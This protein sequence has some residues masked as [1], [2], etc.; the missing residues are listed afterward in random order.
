MEDYVEDYKYNNC[1]WKN[2]KL[3]Y[4]HAERKF[5]EYMS[6]GDMFGRMA[7]AI[8]TL[9]SSLGTIENLLVDTDETYSTR[10]KGIQ[11]LLIIIK[12]ITEKFRYLYNNVH[13]ISE[14]IH[15]KKFAYESKKNV[16]D[17]CEDYHKSYESKLKDLD[18]KKKNYTEAINKAVELF[19]QLKINGKLKKKENTELKNRKENILKKKAEYKKQ[20][21]EVEK[22]RVDYM[23]VQGNIFA[24]EEELERDCTNDFKKYLL[25]FIGNCQNFF[26]NFELQEAE[27]QIID[28]ID[29]VKDN[30]EFAERNKTLMTGPK[31]NLY[32]EYSQDVNYYTEHFDFIKSKLKGKN[33]TESREFTNMLTH[34]VTEFLGEIIKE[35]PDVIH[36]KIEEIAKKLKENE[37]VTDEDFKYIIDRF[38]D[39]FKQFKDWKEKKVGDQDFKKVGK[40]WDERFCYMHTFLKYF[41]KTRVGNKELTPKNFDYLCESMK[42][43][44]TLNDSEDVDYSLCDLVVILSF[45]FYMLD[46][47]AKNG[48]KYVNE[49]IKNCAITQKQGFW[50]GLTRYE[51]NEEIQQ[52]EKVEDTLKE[53]N[54]SLQKLNNSIIAKL[55]SVTYN[56]MQYII[57]SE[58]FNR[59]VYDI[60]KYCKISH[61]S[62]ETVVEMMDAQIQGENL[63]HLVLDKK[64]LLK[65]DKNDTNCTPDGETKG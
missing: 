3:L 22:C 16:L 32:K 23:E 43:I 9:C 41:N 36:Q 18:I 37:V 30:K 5:Q 1:F 45:T 12:Q 8:N 60:F 40:D 14:E 44:L 59:I 15:E 53:G 47:N 21:D 38:N 62:R 26:K 27:K 52:Q 56:I 11:E 20:V 29:G 50:V 49:V 7:D 51:L 57:K 61:D 65:A 28:N 55:M 48:K 4:E 58:T 19:L 31:R 64:L 39:R 33:A 17:M 10:F 46:K 6:V 24:A 13:K 2:T 35:E 54:I 63:K 25:I 34:S 42:L